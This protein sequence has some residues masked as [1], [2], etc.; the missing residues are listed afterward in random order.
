MV[1]SFLQEKKVLPNLQE[2][3]EDT[4]IEVPVWDFRKNVKKF[5]KRNVGFHTP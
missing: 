5:S 2:G 1:I 3:V 4:I